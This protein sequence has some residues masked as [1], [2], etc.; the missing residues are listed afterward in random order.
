MLEIRQL[1]AFKLLKTEHALL[2]LKNWV[3]EL[4]WII[5]LLQVC[6]QSLN[7]TK[8]GGRNHQQD[9]AHQIV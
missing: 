3:K 6:S 7:T 9:Y 5:H 1:A 4:V 2:S 8:M